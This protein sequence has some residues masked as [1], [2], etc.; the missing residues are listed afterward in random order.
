MTFSSVKNAITVNPVVVG[1]AGSYLLKIRGK[2]V[3][4]SNPSNTLSSTTN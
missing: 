3:D 2:I 1:D 4:Q